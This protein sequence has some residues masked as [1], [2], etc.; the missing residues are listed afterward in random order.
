MSSSEPPLKIHRRGAGKLAAIRA[1]AEA[2]RSEAV[3]EQKKVLDMIRSRT[4]VE[5]IEQLIREF[6]VTG[7]G[8]REMMT[9]AGI[10]D[11]LL[12]RLIGDGGLPLTWE[13]ENVPLLMFALAHQHAPTVEAIINKAVESPQ[14][15]LTPNPAGVLPLQALI[16]SNHPRKRD[17]IQQVVEMVPETVNK[18]LDEQK[19]MPLHVAVVADPN[20]V[21]FLLQNGATV[22]AQNA[23][24]QTALQ[25][26]VLSLLPNHVR[27]LLQRGSRLDVADN[28]GNTPLS[29]LVQVCR[30]TQDK[31]AVFHVA[32]P[33]IE[34][35]FRQGQGVVATSVLDGT[36]GAVASAILLAGAAHNDVDAVEAALEVGANVDQIHP[37]THRRALH[38]AVEKNNPNMVDILFRKGTLVN[39]PED[40]ENVASLTAH[41]NMQTRLS[42]RFADQSMDAPAPAA[43]AGVSEPVH[44]P[45]APAEESGKAFDPNP[46][47]SICL[48]EGGIPE[49]GPFQYLAP[50]GHAMHSTCLDEWLAH[51]QSLGTLKCP[52]CKQQV[53]GK[54]VQ[55]GQSFGSRRTT[56]KSR[57]RDRKSGSKGWFYVAFMAVKRGAKT[58]TAKMSNL[59]SG[60]AESEDSFVE[61]GKSEAGMG[62]E[63]K[64]EG[65]V[66]KT[67][68]STRKS[69]KAR[70]TVSPTRKSRKV[71]KTVSSTR[72]SRKVGKTVSPT[73]K[74]RK[75][76]KTV[77]STRKSRKVGKTVSPTRKSRKV[78][79]TVSPTRK[80]RKVDKTVSPTRKSGKVAKT[81]SSTRKSRKARKTVSP[82]RKS[83]K[84]GKTVSPTRKSRKV[85]KTVSPTRKSRKARRSS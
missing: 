61:K 13:S 39:H 23:A 67:V 14:I 31:Q 1:A 80:S 6:G 16:A 72:K 73:R 11:P 3:A 29:T 54:W 65:K 57:R 45:I 49:Y 17:L 63:G 26:A 60:K 76:G 82:T 21:E 8:L 68:S 28:E 27:A 38:H 70:K 55:G 81:V 20:T 84:V 25:Y 83:R 74:S 44:L 64:E 10:Y 59:F 19:R 32:V 2:S 53:T 79:K 85:A 56:G 35:Y 52:L 24:G 40:R 62:K 50:C 46:T 34:E 33:L 71:G 36:C 51:Q 15:L 43:A 58:V 75:V 48:E 7:E 42:D 4:G 78:G 18:A 12:I 30:D 9:A 69:R 37:E 41:E 5:E 77:S 47:C 66:G 22:D